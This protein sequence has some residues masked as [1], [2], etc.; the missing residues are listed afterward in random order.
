[1]TAVRRKQVEV[2]TTSTHSSF[3]ASLAGNPT[4]FVPNNATVKT[5][6]MTASTNV[7]TSSTTNNNTEL[8]VA[9]PNK[10]KSAM[11]RTYTTLLMLGGFSGLIYLGHVALMLLVIAL[12]VAMF[13]EIKKLTLMLSSRPPLPSFRAMHWYWFISATIFVYGKLASFILHA[14]FSATAVPYHSF[15]CFSLYSFGVILFVMSLRKGYYRY[16]FETF[17]FIQLTLLLVV[18]QSSFIV[19]NMFGGLIWF[20]LPALLIV[21]NDCWAYICG[22]FFGRTPLIRLS[23][24]KTWEGFIGAAFITVITGFWL[25]RVLSSW[26]ML[27][28]PKHDLTFQH[29]QCN[30]PEEFLPVLYTL[31]KIL[32]PFTNV[33]RALVLCPVS[34]WAELPVGGFTILPVQLHGIAFA[35]FA[36]LIAPFGGFFA[37]GV[38]RAFRIKDFGETIPGH[39][40]VT[41]RMDCQILMGLFVYV[42]YWSFIHTYSAEELILR[43]QVALN[44]LSAEQ[45]LN[46]WHQLGSALLSKGYTLP[47]IP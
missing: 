14:S 15:I 18:I 26:Q 37:S 38:K 30:L 5:Q 17:A 28:C 45:Q 47:S 7:S 33:V 43:A 19:V 27:V 1:M 44:R 20:I 25:S 6:S 35:M 4:T 8:L 39:G 31:P 22:F 2:H 32:H 42:Y 3:I 46:L 41:D 36:S 10:W 12:Q 34:S 9:N 21:S 23:P 16:Q 11:V 24:K 40:G 29:P 13:R